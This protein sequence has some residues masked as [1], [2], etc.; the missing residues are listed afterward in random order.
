MRR[1]RWRLAPALQRRKAA[2][3]A[4]VWRSAGRSAAGRALAR[5]LPVGSGGPCSPPTSVD[6]SAQLPTGLAPVGHGRRPGFVAP[7]G[8]ERAAADYS[9]AAGDG[10]PPSGATGGRVRPVDAGH[11]VSPHTQNFVRTEYPRTASAHKLCENRKQQPTEGESPCLTLQR[12]VT[13]TART[14]ASHAPCGKRLA[15]LAN[16]AASPAQ[17]DS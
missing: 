17:S 12:P 14:S 6:R 3:E 10:D 11:G 9:A 15:A 16:A 8:D 1:W 7:C 4:A 13:P 5:G 2:Q